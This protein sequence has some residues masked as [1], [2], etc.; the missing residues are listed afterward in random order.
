MKRIDVVSATLI[1]LGLLCVAE[2]GRSIVTYNDTKDWKEVH[3][4]IYS[5]KGVAQGDSSYPGKGP[6]M[7]VKIEAVAYSYVVDYR[8]YRGVGYVPGKKASYRGE[9]VSVYYNP[10]EPKQSTLDHSLDWA[11][12]LTWLF[13]GAA[14]FSAEYFWFRLRVKYRPRLPFR[15][16]KIK[17]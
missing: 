16:S 2:A 15:K 12:L 9:G 8:T 4:V 6:V 11:Y 14:V 10:D 5:V 17:K 13:F 3:G 1:F 7:M